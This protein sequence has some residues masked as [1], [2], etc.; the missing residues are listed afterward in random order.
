MILDPT[1]QFIKHIIENCD[2]KDKTILEVGCG[3]GRITEDLSK[4]AKRVVAIEPDKKLL[5]KAQSELTKDNVE[6]IQSKG[7]S[8][9]F[10]QDSFDVVVY[11]LSLHHIPIDSMKKGLIE[12]TRI[13]KRDGKIII[14]EPYKG[15]TLIEAEEKFGVVGGVERKEKR[16]AREAMQSL[17]GWI[18]G[19]DIFFKTLFYFDDEEDFLKNLLPNYQQKPKELIELL[20]KFLNQ[21]KK[22][23]KI[24][25]TAE[26]R[27][28]V[29]Y[30]QMQQ[31]SEQ[32]S[33]SSL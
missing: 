3:V 16:A 14:I 23:G 8:L 30:R 10:P 27:M 25:L 29:L 21:H 9:K 19:K 11:G 20:K 28:N 17:K 7:E 32:S 4:Y 18:I 22:G 24:I 33:L 13:L 12:T 26:R 2:I 31:N 6:F 15:G 5:Q 1:N